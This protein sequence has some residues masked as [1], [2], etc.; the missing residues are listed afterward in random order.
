MNTA[1]AGRK[2]GTVKGRGV[3][4]P[5]PDSRALSAAFARAADYGRDA[6]DPGRGILE[7][8]AGLVEVHRR[9]EA[10]Q[11]RWGDG[12]MTWDPKAGDMA[13]PTL[14]VE[15]DPLLDAWEDAQRHISAIDLEA[16]RILGEPPLGAVEHHEGLGT[17]FCRMAYLYTIS[18]DRF[19]LDGPDG[20]NRKQLARAYASYEQLA[21]DLVCGRKYL[22][23]PTDGRPG[24]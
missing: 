3:F 8:I 13:V 17:I 1:A 5:L 7:S 6:T 18:F 23:S 4:G 19:V 15:A 24:T 9:M 14:D 12:V 22:P 10:L 21:H 16:R 2:E 11:P 20:T